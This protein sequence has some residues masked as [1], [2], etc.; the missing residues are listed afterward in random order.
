MRIRTAIP[1]DRRRPSQPRRFPRRGTQSPEPPLV[2]LGQ[3]PYLRDGSSS[4]GYRAVHRYFSL[5]YA[6]R[7]TAAV[8]SGRRGVGVP[9]IPG[10]PPDVRARR[11]VAGGRP[12]RLGG[13]THTEQPFLPA[14]NLLRAVH[15]GQLLGDAA[16]GGTPAS[17][18]LS[19]TWPLR[20]VGPGA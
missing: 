1:G 5:G 8:R 19:A 14:G 7:G 9:V 10:G 11:G 6:I 20:G 16:H 2:P 18:G 4:V 13:D 3:H 17:A 15:L 12:G